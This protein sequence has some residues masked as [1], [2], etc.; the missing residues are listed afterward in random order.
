MKTKATSGTSLSRPIKNRFNLVMI[1]AFL[2]L[3]S[4]SDDD[5]ATEPDTRQQFVGTYK[6]NDI[7]A[8]SGYKYEYSVTISLGSKGGLEIFNFADMLNVPVKATAKGNQLIIA[9]QTF[10]NPSG[11]T[12]T[13][14]GSGN[15]ANEVL[16]FNYT[17][18]GYLDYSGNC[19]G[20]KA[21]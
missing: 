11:K 14:A 5:K 1:M 3:A 18:A 12:L 16:T 13:V 2:A 10:K 15:L 21:K 19:T 8:S 20:E 9:S 6:V 7:S 17:T 4:C